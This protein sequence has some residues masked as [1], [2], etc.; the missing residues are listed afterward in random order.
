MRNTALEKVYTD[1]IATRAPARDAA[2]ALANQRVRDV[3][4]LVQSLPERSKHPI[5]SG[6]TN[7]KAKDGAI[8]MANVVFLIK[9]FGSALTAVVALVGVL[10]GAIYVDM[11]A[12]MV[13]AKSDLRE[14]AR[15]AR[16]LTQ[17]VG[18]L[19]AVVARIDQKLSDQKSQQ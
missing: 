10:I 7:L 17:K 9:A 15:D 2:L 19:T 14:I 13:E 8:D 11:R 1:A 18:D 5:Y 3:E 4:K 6:Q 16:E 12:D